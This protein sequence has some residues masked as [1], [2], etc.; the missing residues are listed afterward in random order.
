MRE[1][2]RKVLVI[3]LAVAMLAL[4]ISAAFATA[5]TTVITGTLTMIDPE[6]YGEIRDLGNSGNQIWTFTDAPFEITGDIEG[7]GVYNGKWIISL[8]DTFPYIEFVAAK[9]VY[10]M[11]VEVD[12]ASGVLTLGLPNNG[13]VIV[14]GG[15]DGLKNLHGTGTLTPLSPLDYIV[16]INAHWDP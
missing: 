5:P 4:P 16:T 1:V 9:G 13:K 12:G 7:Y 6:L 3:A 10:I 15:T 11:D 2:K 14:L 8:I